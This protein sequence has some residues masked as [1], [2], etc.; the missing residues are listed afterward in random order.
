MRSIIDE[1]AN[2]ETEA[3][4]LRADAVAAARERVVQAKNDAEK[5]LNHAETNEREKTRKALEDADREGNALSESILADMRAEAEKQ[6]A[7]ADG[8]MDGAVSYLLEK[9]RGIV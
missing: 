2:A 8:K 6:C 3:E 1:I 5:R 9:V 7:A 4:K